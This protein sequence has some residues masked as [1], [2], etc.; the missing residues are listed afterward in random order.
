MTETY[1][2]IQVKRMRGKLVVIGMGK[3]GR[4]QAYIKRSVPIAAKRMT[5]PNYKSDLAAAVAELFA[6]REAPG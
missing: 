6:S 2:T 1:G 4:G 3:T 5:D